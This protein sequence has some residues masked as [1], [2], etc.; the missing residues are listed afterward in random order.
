MVMKKWEVAEGLECCAHAAL[1]CGECPYDAQRRRWMENQ[2]ANCVSLLAADV[3]ELLEEQVP[4]VLAFDEL[5]G[6]D[7]AVFVEYNAA[8]LNR[9]GEWAFVDFVTTWDTPARAWLIR[10]DTSSREI[11]P[12]LDRDY[13]TT[14][15]C[16]TLRPGEMLADAVAWTGTKGTEEKEAVGKRD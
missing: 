13:N 16:W 4:R 5:A 3:L 6:H 10:K 14:W 11:M 12:C 1:A 7:G 9:P 15:R 8:R 2:G